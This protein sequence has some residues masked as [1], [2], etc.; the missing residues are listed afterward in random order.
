MSY[1]INNFRK[2]DH[3]TVKA[4]FDV[5]F[6]TVKV[7]G[8]NLIE[9]ASGGRFISSPSEKYTNR[10]GEQKFKDI[11]VFTDD[12]IRYQLEKDV[13]QLFQAAP[14]P[15]QQQSAPAQAD[16]AFNPSDDIPF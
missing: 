15:Q 11:A 4:N 13:S 10:N 12:L 8:F 16:P 5:D 6:G 3:P 1:R 14:D 7:R 2:V 9:T